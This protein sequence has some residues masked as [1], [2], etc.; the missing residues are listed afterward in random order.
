ML[1]GREPVHFL[2]V[3]KNTDVQGRLGNL[4]A[5]FRSR[6]SEGFRFIYYGNEIKCFNEIVDDGRVGFSE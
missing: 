5:A 4:S 1:V 2:Q 3:Y 6:T